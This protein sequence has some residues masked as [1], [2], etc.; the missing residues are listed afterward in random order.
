VAFLLIIY[1]SFWFKRL[2]YHLGFFED[3]ETA[4]LAYDA[5]ARTLFGE[6]AWVLKTTLIEGLHDL[7][8]FWW[9]RGS[10]SSGWSTD[11]HA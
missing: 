3:A 9:L 1:N 4:A 5:A 6:F 7:S 8:A 2:C 10:S 11:P